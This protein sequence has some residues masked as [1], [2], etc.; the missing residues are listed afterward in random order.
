[1]SRSRSLDLSAMNE[2]H[3]C[4][5][6]KPHP[7][8]QPMLSLCAQGSCVIAFMS[9]EDRAGNKAYTRLRKLHAALCTLEA[10]RQP[11]T[12]SPT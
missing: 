5:C 6:N 8:A 2:Q 1:M 11:P 7:T 10:V 12:C 9:D 4:P 3:A